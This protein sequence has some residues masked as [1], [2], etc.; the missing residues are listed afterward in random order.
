MS[1]NLDKI[2]NLLD[3][4]AISIPYLDILLVYYNC[5]ITK[6]NKLIHKT[7]LKEEILG[8]FPHFT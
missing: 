5:R 6:Q 4:Y 1:I 7:Q 2:I 8:L 3:N